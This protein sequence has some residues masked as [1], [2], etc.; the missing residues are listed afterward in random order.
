[1]TV[2]QL[3]DE[4]FTI[5]LHI[6][7]NQIH[8][9]FWNKIYVQSDH[10]EFRS[11]SAATKN[12]LFE[13]LI[14]PSLRIHASHFLCGKYNCSVMLQSPTHII[15]HLFS[16]RS[17]GIY[18]RDTEG[19]IY[20][21][22]HHVYLKTPLPERAHKN[23]KSSHNVI[24]WEWMNGLLLLA[25]GVEA[26]FILS[27]YM[28]TLC[29]H[30]SPGPISS[31]PPHYRLK[32]SHT[33]KVPTTKHTFQGAQWCCL[34]NKSQPETKSISVGCLCL[35]ACRKCHQSWGFS[36]SVLLQALCAEWKPW[37]QR[38]WIW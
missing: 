1:M 7:F 29:N 37:K 24:G 30:W 10:L 18:Q 34:R 15:I 14:E 4:H 32:I 11:S 27:A 36:L 6:F 9:K 26:S 5:Y 38:V 16:G 28:S 35:C 13:I 31:F 33:H 19:G 17:W 25:R 21:G 22:T 3:F 8:F 12:V 20:Q 23:K 2:I